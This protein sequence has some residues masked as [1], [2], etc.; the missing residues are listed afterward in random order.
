MK[1]IK[2]YYLCKVLDKQEKNMTTKKKKRKS[3]R[4]KTEKRINRILKKRNKAI[5][6]FSSMYGVPSQTR[7]SLEL[8]K[9]RK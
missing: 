1:H 7:Y 6:A 3:I 4:K 5:L 9:N 2:K 8:Q